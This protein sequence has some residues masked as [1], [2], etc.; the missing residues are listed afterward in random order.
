MAGS[1]IGTESLND[2]DSKDRK[3]EEMP[4]S[5]HPD[6]PQTTPQDQW[7]YLSR[8]T[9]WG[10]VIGFV[11]LFFWFISPTWSHPPLQTP[12]SN[13]DIM[14]LI[15]NSRSMKTNDPEQIRISAARFLVDYL[16][17]EAQSRLTDFRIGIAYFSGPGKL[18]VLTD[19]RTVHDKRI[20]DRLTPLDQDALPQETD[21]KDPL[22]FALTEFEINSAYVPAKAVFFFT[23]GQPAPEGDEISDDPEELEDYFT[24]Q[25]RGS[26]RVLIDQ[27]KKEG[28]EVHIL[29]LGEAHENEQQ[30]TDRVGRDHYHPLSDVSDLLALYHDLVNSF[31]GEPTE[32]G[33]TMEITRTTTITYEVEPYLARIH[34]IFSFFTSDPSSPLQV[35]LR[36]PHGGI[37]GPVGWA[38]DQERY[39]FY[40]IERP[41]EGVW[42][43]TATVTREGTLQYWVDRYYPEIEA[44]LRPAVVQ[45]GLPFTVT[46]GLTYNQQVFTDTTGL[47]LVAELRTSTGQTATVQLEPFP[48]DD[49]YSGRFEGIDLSGPYTVT[50]QTRIGDRVIAS[51]PQWGEIV[52]V[53]VSPTPSPTP[54]PPTPTTDGLKRFMNTSVVLTVGWVLVIVAVILVLLLAVWFLAR[55]GK[56]QAPK[57]EEAPLDGEAD[58]AVPR[59]RQEPSTATEEEYLKPDCSDW[60]SR[61]S[62]EYAKPGGHKLD[63]EEYE[64][65]LRPQKVVEEHIRKWLHDTVEKVGIFIGKGDVTGALKCWDEGFRN[66]Q[67]LPSTNVLKSAMAED[68]KGFFAVVQDHMR[69]L[70]QK[71]SDKH[72]E[73]WGGIHDIIETGTKELTETGHNNIWRLLLLGNHRLREKVEEVFQRVNDA[74]DVELEVIAKLLK[75]R[76]IH[77]PDW[78]VEGLYLFLGKYRDP[79]RLLHLLQTA[80]P[81]EEADARTVEAFNTLVEKHRNLLEGSEQFMTG[82][83][84]KDLPPEK[85]TGVID[86]WK[87][88]LIDEWKSLLSEMSH[89][90]KKAH[91]KSQAFRTARN[92]EHPDREGVAVD[93]SG[94]ALYEGGAELYAF[95]DNFEASRFTE[96][97]PPIPENAPEIWQ[98]TVGICKTL[99]RIPNA[100]NKQEQRDRFLEEAE[101]LSRSEALGVWGSVPRVLVMVGQLRTG[102]ISFSAGLAPELTLD[103]GE[104]TD[105]TIIV[106][107]EGG[108][109]AAEVS[110]EIRKEGLC[111]YTLKGEDT[112][113]S[114]KRVF[115]FPGETGSV[116]FFFKKTESFCEDCE[117]EYRINY[118]ELPRHSEEF[119]EREG[120][121]FR[122]S[123][124]GLKPATPATQEDVAEVKNHYILD[125]PVY[126]K[127]FE[128]DPSRKKIQEDIEEKIK[129]AAEGYGERSY[130]FWGARKTGKTSLLFHL[131]KNLMKEEEREES[132][133]TFVTVY[134]PSVVLIEEPDMSPKK[135]WGFLASQI[136]RSIRK[137]DNVELKSYPTSLKSE[138]LLSEILYFLTEL[139]GILGSPR[140]ISLILMFDDADAI[141]YIGGQS[142]SERVGQTIMEKYLKPL[143][144]SN[145]NLFTVLAGERHDEDFRKKYGPDLVRLGL[146]DRETTKKLENKS[147]PLKYSDQS[148][149]YLWRV[150]GGYPSLVQLL[151]YQVIED[152][153][154]EYRRWEQSSANPPDAKPIPHPPEKTITLVNVRQ[155]M[156]NLFRNSEVMRFFDYIYTYSFT[157][158]EKEA[159]RNV[160]PSVDP[161]TMSI[162][163]EGI[164]DIPEEVLNALKDKE[165][166]ERKAE[167]KWY[168]RVGFFKLWL[169]R[170]GARDPKN[171]TQEQE[172]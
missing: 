39:Q 41:A 167:G 156:G 106:C 151:C 135:F 75:E 113:R 45:S 138:M 77:R 27:L 127:F 84:V 129:A 73:Y 142:G 13:L 130:Y 46:A 22:S 131:E 3:V 2:Y 157:D 61:A 63:R 137:H 1:E 71:S 49:T 64:E 161:I 23:D 166:I 16:H 147:D 103:S 66:Q 98:E 116:T 65:L 89:A 170:I 58:E 94:L 101:K 159:L 163:P 146:F 62:P 95:L 80:P 38:V 123:L 37:Y 28:A 90:F 134:I 124:P 111:G 10:F 42:T 79:G 59:S 29:A 108:G 171:T 52:A 57:G 155:A 72:I 36:G 169:D 18:E 56:Q 140:P 82:G 9:R 7:Q 92:L 145:M 102:S 86:K 32:P 26:V 6:F 5:R 148:L 15:D 25:E 141:L 110:V 158:G 53:P 81:P 97:L 164:K 153:K 69:T 162:N 70:D 93:Q 35:T 12:P 128:E 117:V 33:T 88:L 122:F 109:G 119:Q 91:D 121:S 120:P 96:N 31:L 14:L 67:V 168:L 11:L 19:L 85:L 143:E 54:L 47:E 150:T 24:N 118:S 44:S 51:E 136:W 100:E 43:A 104:E 17:L 115:L 165:I 50:V 105:C 112:K 172:Q 34:F 83:W 107:N 87:S 68:R 21:F 74:G 40:S 48:P 20:F 139:E 154:R 55:R 30:W 133:H 4:S 78:M 8:L 126:G 99:S 160:A 149:A 152:W 125:D 144:Q 114:L 132:Q 76:W 60:V